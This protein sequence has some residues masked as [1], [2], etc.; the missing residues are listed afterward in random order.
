MPQRPSRQRLSSNARVGSEVGAVGH[1]MFRFPESLARP[2]ARLEDCSRPTLRRWSPW[3]MTERASEWCR[4]AVV[5]VNH[6]FV[7]RAQRGA[8]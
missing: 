7:P 2:A 3:R 6:V 5:D 8:T 1:G 4:N